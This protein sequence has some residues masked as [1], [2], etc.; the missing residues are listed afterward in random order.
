MRL[1]QGSKNLFTVSS[2]GATLENRLDQVTQ[3]PHSAEIKKLFYKG[4]GQ[5]FLN[6]HFH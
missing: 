5:H 4:N 3:K 1:S 2:V 6:T